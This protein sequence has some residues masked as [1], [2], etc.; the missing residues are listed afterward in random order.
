VL[1]ENILSRFLRYV[2]IDTVSNRKI[3]ETPTTAG[4]WELAKMLEREA[5]ALGISDV[6]LT[7]YCYLIA[8]IP[9][10]TSKP[11]PVTGFLAHLDTSDEV[12]GHNVNPVTEKN[13]AGDTIIKTDGTSLL[14]GDDKAGVAEIL[15]AAEYI[16]AH[17]AIE[18]GEIELIFTPDEETGKGLPRFPADLIHSTVCYTVDGSAQGELEIECFNAYS[19][20][21]RFTGRVIHPGY[22]RGK[23]VNAALM[24]A[25][26]AAMLPRNET[27]EATDGYYGYYCLMEIQGRQDSATLTIILRDFER[28]GIERRLAAL[29]SLA[30]AVETQFPDGKVTVETQP[31]YFNMRQKIEEKPEILERLCAAAEKI[32]VTFRLKP[33]R[34]GTD[35]SRLTEMGIPTPNIWTGA[36]NFHSLDEYANLSEMASACRLVIELMKA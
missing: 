22:A 26:Y 5:R 14:G 4:Q 2:K 21:V 27:P 20:T 15:T 28:E 33:V 29:E 25:Y 32:G 11:I 1:E 18:H 17:P 24:A 35:G 23:L 7:A 9:S 10:N 31:S 12:N 13:A 34:G 6:T 3:S 16:L 19:A 36:Y 8:R 30:R